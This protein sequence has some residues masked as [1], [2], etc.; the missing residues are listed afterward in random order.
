ML[1]VVRAGHAQV[2]DLRYAMDRLEAMR[3]PVLG[4]LLNDMRISGGARATTARIVLLAEQG[5][6]MSAPADIRARGLGGRSPR[7]VSAP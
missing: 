3:A 4:T 7:G 1:L 6:I 5:G 2:D